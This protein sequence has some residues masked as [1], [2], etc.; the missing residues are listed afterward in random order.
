M[1]VKHTTEV[2]HTYHLILNQAEV[3]MLRD[4]LNDVLHE[5]VV[6]GDQEEFASRLLTPLRA[7]VVSASKIYTSSRES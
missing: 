6:D 7:A 4:L 1:E 2:V 3:E 5:E